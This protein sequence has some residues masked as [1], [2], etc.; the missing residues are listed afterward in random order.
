MPVFRVRLEFFYILSSFS[1]YLWEED[2]SSASSFGMDGSENS[3]H[4][5]IIVEIKNMADGI[6]IRKNVVKGQISEFKIKLM[7]ASDKDKVIENI[8]EKLVEKKKLVDMQNKSS[9]IK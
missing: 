3:T 2:K 1:N 6:N 7:K 8:K 9:N 4:K 5:I